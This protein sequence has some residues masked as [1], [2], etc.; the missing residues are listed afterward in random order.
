MDINGIIEKCKSGRKK[1]KMDKSCDEEY[2]SNLNQE[3]NDKFFKRNN[4]L[5]KILMYK[6]YDCLK[7]T[8][9]LNLICKNKIRKLILKYKDSITNF[10]LDNAYAKKSTDNNNVNNS[11]LNSP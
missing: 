8:K 10:I 3:I 6:I 5:E 2:L 4:E 9:K 11:L 7:L 1:K